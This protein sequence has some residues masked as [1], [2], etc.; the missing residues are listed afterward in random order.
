MKNGTTGEIEKE[1]VVA[2]AGIG[3]AALGFSLLRSCG[4]GR[5]LLKIASVVIGL[6]EM[7]K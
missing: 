4:K 1:Y 5:D 7:I 3:L 2:G 6:I